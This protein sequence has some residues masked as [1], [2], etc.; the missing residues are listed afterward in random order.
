MKKLVPFLLGHRT[1]D[2]CFTNANGLGGAYT[3]FE[4]YEPHREVRTGR[5]FV[6]G[7]KVCWPSDWYWGDTLPNGVYSDFETLATEE[8]IFPNAESLMPDNPLVPDSF[9]GLSG[10]LIWSRW[11]TYLY[12]SLC[13]Y[14][15]AVF[16]PFESLDTWEEPQTSGTIEAGEATS[17]TQLGPKV[18]TTWSDNYFYFGATS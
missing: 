16:E 5:M 11:A 7:R 17:D 18:T 3:T 4:L 1:D 13:A 6:S 12:V 10:R 15:S 9:D 2:V 8:V 14:P